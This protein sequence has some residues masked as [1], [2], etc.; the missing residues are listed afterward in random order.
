MKTFVWKGSKAQ[1]QKGKND[2]LIMSLAIGSWLYESSPVKANTKQELN[3][4]MLAAFAVNN[5]GKEVP[6]NP[7]AGRK[8]HPYTVHHAN[9]MPLTSGSDA[10]YGDL[11][12][13]L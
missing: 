6:Q 11:G 2:D 1:A 12:W 8:F 3:K 7:W 13:L 5:K 9:D 10:P 4:A